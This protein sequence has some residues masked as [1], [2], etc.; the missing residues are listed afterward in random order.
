[1]RDPAHIA[2]RMDH[3]TASGI[4]KVFDLG[5]KL[6]DPIDLSIGMPHFD[7][8]GPIKD[9]A[10][11]AIQRGQNRYTPTQGIEPL[12]MAVA[13]ACQGE[14]GWGDDRSYMVTSGVAGALTLAIFATLDPGQEVIVTDPHF[15]MYTYITRMAGGVPVSVDTYDDFRPDLDRI[16]DA[17]TDKT[18]MIVINSPGNP[19]GCV[20][21]EDELRGIAEI[22]ERHGLLVLSDE[23]YNVFCYD[24]PYLSIAKFYENT[25]LMRGF[26]KSFGMPGWRMGW[27]T[28]PDAI[29]DRMKTLQQWTFVCAPS[30]A[31]A[32]GVVAMATDMSDYVDAYRAKRDMV[33]AALCDRFGWIK[34]SGA[35]YAFVPAPGGDA[36][37]F[38]T[39]AIANNVLV[40]PGSVFSSRDTH[41]RISY[42]AE[43][44]KLAQGLEIL[45]GL[46]EES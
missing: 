8:P 21:T 46:A 12:R 35:F 37:E 14:F 40:I 5:A 9:E 31:Q 29:L 22:A 1:M 41:F 30:M 32:A 4:R 6:T 18:R 38:V 36:T 11:A 45:V 15:V 19:T 16:A 13:D 23:I 7:V 24:Q 39:K 3:I 25:M 2:A 20:Y 10:I 28:G 34:Q 44:D 43:D 17:V 26:S 42:A 27:C 33:A